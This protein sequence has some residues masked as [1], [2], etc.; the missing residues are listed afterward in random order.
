MV[1]ND[2]LH[3][4][5]EGLSV[6]KLFQM[7]YNEVSRMKF[8]AHTIL[9]ARNRRNDIKTIVVF[10]FFSRAFKTKLSAINR[11]WNNKFPR[12]EQYSDDV[13]FWVIDKEERVYRLSKSDFNTFLE[14]DV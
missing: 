1:S 3:I 2:F 10:A 5:A 13:E 4:R 6:A 7:G 11:V 9:Q 8:Q 14:G 12:L